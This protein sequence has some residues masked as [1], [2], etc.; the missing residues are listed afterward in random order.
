VPRGYVMVVIRWPKKNTNK[1]YLKIQTNQ[2]KKEVKWSE[3]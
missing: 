2:F 1:K 3:Y